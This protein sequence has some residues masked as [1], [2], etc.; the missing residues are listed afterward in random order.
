[1]LA[2]TGQSM[3]AATS[4][5]APSASCRITST[6]GRIAF[7]VSA[8]SLRLSPLRTLEAAGWKLETCAP[9]RLPAISKEKS[10]R[11]LFSKK[12][13]IWVSP[14]SRLSALRAPRLNS[15]QGSASSRIRLMS[16]ADRPS[17]PS[18]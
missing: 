2:G 14:A 5:A 8:V 6:S 3:I 15:S 18:R 9:S 17:I 10:V 4:A 7:R 12:A 11:V 13:L 1:M 16:A